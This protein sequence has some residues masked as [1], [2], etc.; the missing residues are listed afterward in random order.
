[1]TFQTKFLSES[2]QIL[3]QLQIYFLRNLS[4]EVE[5]KLNT[6]VDINFFNLFKELNA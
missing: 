2:I 4:T 1:M 3:G 6:I 5:I